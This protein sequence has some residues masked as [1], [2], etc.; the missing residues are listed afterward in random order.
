MKKIVSLLI[1]ISIFMIFNHF[2]VNNLRTFSDNALELDNET[3][4]IVDKDSKDEY[5]IYAV[6]V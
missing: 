6:R 3:F 5:D 4:M 2:G 1:I